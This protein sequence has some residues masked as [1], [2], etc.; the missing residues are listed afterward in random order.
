MV[1]TLFPTTSQNVCV[2]ESEMSDM[3]GFLRKSAGSEENPEK[4][5]K[6]VEMKILK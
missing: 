3:I 2:S 6:L 1:L 4:S 5:G